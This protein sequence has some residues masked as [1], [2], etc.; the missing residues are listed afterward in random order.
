V[1]VYP[2][3]DLNDAAAVEHAFQEIASQH[4]MRIAIVVKKT[5]AEMIPWLRTVLTPSD[6]ARVV[7]IYTDRALA[8]A[9]D[10][11]DAT[12]AELLAAKLDVPAA[13]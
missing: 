4:L 5:E 12:V 6:R 1:F 8:S 11:R 13:E 2:P 9:D 10:R 7:A 3:V